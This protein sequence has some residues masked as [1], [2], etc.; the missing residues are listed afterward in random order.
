M[1]EATKLIRD[2]CD[3]ALNEINI[4]LPDVIE[5]ISKKDNLAVKAG[6]PWY[7]RHKLAFIIEGVKRLKIDVGKRAVLP[8][9]LSELQTYIHVIKK[10]QNDPEWDD[11]KQSLVNPQNFHHTMIKLCLADYLSSRS[12]PIKLVPKKD[13][14]SPDLMIRA[15]HP[16]GSGGGWIF[17]ECYQPS[18]LSNPSI[19]LTKKTIDSI[20]R[21]VMRKAR[22]QFT[23]YQPGVMILGSYYQPKQQIEQLKAKIS[24]RF[25]GSNRL[26]LAGVIFVDFNVEVTRKESLPYS[27]PRIRIDL[28]RNPHYYGQ[29]Q[30]GS[31]DVQDNLPKITRVLPLIHQ[32]KLSLRTVIRSQSSTVP[33]YFVG[34]GNVNLKCG[35][36]K[37]TLGKDVWKLSLNNIILHCPKCDKYN[38]IMK[39]NYSK[40]QGFV[41]TLGAKPGGYNFTNPVNLRIGQIMVGIDQLS[42][43]P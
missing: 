9:V 22:K 18:S 5:T 25:A 2:Q 17:A 21:N 38:E 27:T 1:G 40:H 15:L 33:P 14:S 7:D 31:Q 20:I 24:N 41:A 35:K 30:F 34:K 32:S 39:F 36:C 42:L 6:K 43:K 10:M 28:V 12:H 37:A 13:H 8:N 16:D 11:V 29:V 3:I 19:K 26:Y 23:S 4:L